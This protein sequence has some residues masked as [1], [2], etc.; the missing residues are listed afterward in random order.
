LDRS[1]VFPLGHE[2]FTVLLL[3]LLVLLVLL[4]L[5][6]SC[7]SMCRL[8]DESQLLRKQSTGELVQAAAAVLAD[9]ASWMPVAMDGPVTACRVRP[10][11]AGTL[12]LLL[13]L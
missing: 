11:E 6:G 12:L 4:L 7:A 5:L 8:P 10:D 13:L 9:A 3:L 2:N 1:T